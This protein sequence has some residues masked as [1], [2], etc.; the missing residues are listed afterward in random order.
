M[1]DSYG[2][3]INNQWAAAT[4]GKTQDVIATGVAPLDPG[5]LPLI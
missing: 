5:A 4:S 3:F 2:L 1:Y